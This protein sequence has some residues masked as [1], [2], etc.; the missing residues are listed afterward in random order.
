M[1]EQI[2]QST[3]SKASTRTQNLRAR[4]VWFAVTLSLV[5]YIDRVAMAQAAPF[6]AREF[7]L[8]RI[9]VGWIFSAFAL[10][11]ALFEIPGG[12]MGDRFGPRPVLLR[13]VTWWSFF[14]A[15][16]GWVNSY[17]QLLACR[18]LFGAGEAGCYPTIARLFQSWLAPDDRARAQGYVW[19]SSRWAGAFT[20]LLALWLINLVSW[21]F[22]FQVFGLVGLVWVVAFWVG[23]RPT[24]KPH[25]QGAGHF[26]SK[27]YLKALRSPTALLLFAQ[28][29]AVSWG[30]SFYITWLPTYVL[31]GR[32]AGQWLSSVL[33][34]MPLLFGGAGCIAGGLLIPIL[35]RRWSRARARGL[36]G[37]VG[38][39]GAGALLL[40]SLYVQQTH[41]ALLVIAL[42]SFSN[43]LALAP[44]WDACSDAGGPWTG[45]LS[46]AM[47][48]VGNSAGFF[49]PMVIGYTLT[50]SGGN[51]SWP[52]L[53]SAG[54]YLLGSL[55]WL[56]IRSRGAIDNYTDSI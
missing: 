16:T 33:S 44:A 15:A 54:F 25:L 12:W 4:V 50:W 32:G 40:L 35:G 45:S 55:S 2:S 39:L 36:L 8:T 38:C 18:F 17:T 3:D 7:S 53:I 29:F 30:W 51:W 47:N 42:A 9:E 20:P 52:F 28:Y 14:T 56:G 23:Y 27:G 22:A 37:A 6:V 31:E 10:A 41:L 49:A 1:I 5:T 13:I 48:M 43:D 26:Q 34:T 11:Y 21:R 19:L 24:A 46:G